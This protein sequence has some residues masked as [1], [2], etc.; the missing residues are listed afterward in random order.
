MRDKAPISRVKILFVMTVYEYRLLLRCANIMFFLH[1]ERFFIDV[2]RFF[3]GLLAI[4]LD[5][6]MFTKNVTKHLV[7][8]FL[9]SVLLLFNSFSSVFHLSTCCL[10]LHVSCHAAAAIVF[11]GYSS[12]QFRRVCSRGRW[13]AWTDTTTHRL[14]PWRFPPL[15]GRR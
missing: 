14:S 2:F 10:R 15:C 6:F 9:L 7:R 8:S 3:F 5:C 13:P 11:C 1:I 4:I 12:L